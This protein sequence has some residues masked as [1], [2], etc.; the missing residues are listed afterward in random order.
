[1]QMTLALVGILTGLAVV[2]AAALYLRGY[3][4][5]SWDDPDSSVIASDKPRSGSAASQQKRG[6]RAGTDQLRVL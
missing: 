3:F 6:K 5:W 2:F 4:R 1:M